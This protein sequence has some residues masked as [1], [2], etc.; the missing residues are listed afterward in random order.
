MSSSPVE[1]KSLPSDAPPSSLRWDSWP[2]KENLLGTVVLS[3]GLGVI[4]FLIQRATG[5]THLGVLATAA[6]VLAMWRF[7]LPTRYELSPDGVCRWVLGR[8]REIPWDTIR[9]YEICR[10]GILLFP[11]RDDCTLDVF[12][13]MY[14]PWGPHRKEVLALASYYLDQGSNA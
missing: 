2:A 12:R 13:A 3:T 14:L 10:N 7:F 1:H 11:F 8:C 5:E 4:G 6:L 9:R